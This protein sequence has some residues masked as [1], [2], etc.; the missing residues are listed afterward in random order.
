MIRAVII[1]DEPNARR[2]LEK[3]LKKTSCF[4]IVGQCGNAVEGVKAINK[5][6]PDVVFSISRCQ[7][8]VVL[9]CSA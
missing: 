7:L 9:N 1:D 2:E 3:L 5:E 8:S 4:D 6:R